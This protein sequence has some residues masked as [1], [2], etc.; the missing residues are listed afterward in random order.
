MPAAARLGDP[1]QCNSC[2]HGCIACPH[3]TKGIIVTGSGDV[4]INGLPAGR[5][6]CTDLGVHAVC[7]GPNIFQLKKGS[8]TVYVNKKPMARKGDQTQHC[9]GTGE[10]TAGSPNVFA[11]DGADAEGLVARAIQALK[12]LLEKAAK[13][14]EGKEEKASDSHE[15]GED[16]GPAQ[17]LAS[18]GKGEDEK[19]KGSIRTAGWDLQRASNGQEVEIQVACKE[20]KGQLKVEI[21]ARSSDP[22]QDKCVQKL[23]MPAG[24]EA[25][26]KVKLEIPGDAAP[27]NECFFY[28][29]VKDEQGGEK[30]SPM[31]YVDR[32]PFRFST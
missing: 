8:G 28:Y 9:G 1:T 2:A 14:K 19:E 17:D 20:G 22:S 32:A 4:K 25:K 12:I 29:V 15:G 7:C 16:K 30:K 31:L 26:K 27:Q 11:D 18:E 5:A 6:E 23:D 13:A 21:W 10:I 3:S 24:D